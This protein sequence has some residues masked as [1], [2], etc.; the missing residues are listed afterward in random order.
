MVAHFDANRLAV[1]YL[2]VAGL[3]PS[4]TLAGGRPTRHG[5]SKDHRDGQAVSHPRKN[6]R[7]LVTIPHFFDGGGTGEF[8]S[9]GPNLELRLRGIASTIA[10]LHQLFG[11]S[12]SKVI[13]PKKFIDVNNAEQYDID[14]V[15]CTAGDR[16]LLDHLDLPP[17]WYERHSTEVDGILLPFECHAVL[18]Q[19]FGD[20]DYYCYLEDDLEIRDPWFFLKQAWFNDHVGDHSVLLPN[21]FEL[22]RSASIAR[23]YIDDHPSPAFAARWQKQDEQPTLGGKVMGTEVRFYRPNNPHAGC[24]FLTAAQMARWLEAPWFLDRDAAFVGPLESAATLGIMKTF[25]VYK[26]APESAAFLEIM[27]INNRYLGKRIGRS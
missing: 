25:R 8:G 5:Q 3:G 1:L 19:R 24:F 15:V 13:H 10:A 2:P 21:R 6:R 26:P 4:R 12:Q 27:H 14:C 9:T 22:A 18:Q 16:H 20:Y 11:G 7:I 23:L 17:A